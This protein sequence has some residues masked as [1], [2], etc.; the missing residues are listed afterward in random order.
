MFTSY[1]TCSILTG[2]VKWSHHTWVASGLGLEIP[3][4][5][6]AICEQASMAW[7]PPHLE[8]IWITTTMRCSAS[9][10]QIFKFLFSLLNTEGGQ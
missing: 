3:K 4:D 5:C 6:R 9:S 1:R 2:N 7:S 8:V 10:F